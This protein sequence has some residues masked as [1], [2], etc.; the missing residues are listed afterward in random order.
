MEWDH[1]RFYW[2]ELMTRDAEQAK[3]FYRDSIGW[4]FEGMPM[5][6]G[7]YWLAIADGRPAGGIFE[8]SGA[9]LDDGPDRWMSFLAVDDVDT[10]IKRAKKG[11]ATIIRGPFDVPGIGRIAVL[12]EPGGAPIG[13]MT[14]AKR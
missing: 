5:E 2:N 13:W 1:G 9:A 6:D 12:N 11:G 14:P 7:T 10:R 4:E 3:T 8:M